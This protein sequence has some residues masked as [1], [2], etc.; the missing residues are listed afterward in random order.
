MPI[1]PESRLGQLEFYEAHVPVWTL[2]VAEIGLTAPQVTALSTLVTAARTAYDAQQP[3]RNAA[4]AATQSFYDA[5]AA[6]HASGSDL[7]ATIKTYASSTGSPAVYNAA[8]IPPPA[9]PTPAPPPAQPDD[10]SGTIDTFGVITL[11]WRATP[12]GPA[13]GIFFDVERRTGSGTWTPMG[14]TQETTFQDAAAGQQ[15]A[16]TNVAYR[17]R[18][19][20]G[21]EL[22]AWSDPLDVSFGGG[23]DGIAGF[24]GGEGEVAEAA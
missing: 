10:L 13:S 12:K 18:G 8:Q 15:A 2:N 1:V 22:S 20:R 3:A 5:V 16:T 4:K 9:P 7:I 24:V 14:A 23:Q 6:A 21:A 11:S 19:R 17:V